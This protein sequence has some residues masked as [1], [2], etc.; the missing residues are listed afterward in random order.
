MPGNS[1]GFCRPPRARKSQELPV[2]RTDRASLSR[3]VSHTPGSHLSFSLLLNR[4]VIHIHHALFHID[5]IR[6]SQHVAR[7]PIGVRAR[8]LAPCPA[9]V[10]EAVHAAAAHCGGWLCAGYYSED[11]NPDLAL[12]IHQ[13]GWGCLGH[14]PRCCVL[15]IGLYFDKLFYPPP[16]SC[17]PNHTQEYARGGV[18]EQQKRESA[19]IAQLKGMPIAINTRDANDQ[20]YEVCVSHRR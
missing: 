11:W 5:C 18:E 19:F 9:S 2:D 15:A 7:N 20:H 1:N 14:A 10:G 8:E 4:S 3:T 13:G 12:P 16:V 6:R 17:S